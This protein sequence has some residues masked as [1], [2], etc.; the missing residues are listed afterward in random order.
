RLLSYVKVTEATYLTEAIRLS[1]FLFK[2]PHQQHLAEQLDQC[3][4]IS[5][6]QALLLITFQFLGFFTGCARRRSL[7][8]FSDGAGAASFIGA[9]SRTGF[10]GSIA[11]W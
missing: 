2:A 5:L 11:H 8:L 1:R 6:L 9:S 7:R 4:A 3:L 10:C